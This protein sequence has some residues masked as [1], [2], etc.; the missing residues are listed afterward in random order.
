MVAIGFVTSQSETLADVCGGGDP[1]VACDVNI[2]YLEYKGTLQC[3][4]SAKRTSRP[5]RDGCRRPRCSW[6][7]SGPGW[8]SIDQI[9]KNSIGNY[10][11]YGPV[12]ADLGRSGAGSLTLSVW[13]ARGTTTVG[14][15]V[16][17]LGA[18]WPLFGTAVVSAVE[19]AGF[20]LWPTT[21]VTD[22]EPLPHSENHFDIPL[23][24]CDSKT[25]DVYKS[26]SRSERRAVRERLRGPFEQLLGLFEPR[27]SS[28][29][30][31][32]RT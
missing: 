12:L 32:D 30:A 8:S 1:R 11:A 18:R 25:A 6:F 16:G 29:F 31:T 5:P 4:S 20:E 26:L 14:D 15:L 27:Q 3:S 2:L 19:A 10:R 17:G 23:P 13:A 9:I 24:G 7:T 21:L 22:G 28:D